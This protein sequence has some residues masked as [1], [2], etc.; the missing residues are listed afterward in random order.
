MKKIN[1]T[2]SPNTLTQYAANNPTAGWNSFRNADAGESHKGLR[3]LI[4][5]DQ[6]GLCAYCETNVSGLPEHRRRIEHYHPKSDDSDATQNWAL[7]WDNVI[8]VCLGGEDNMDKISYPLPQNLSCDSHKEYFVKENKL[9]IAPEGYLINPLHLI[10]TP[11]LFEFVKATGE[12]KV[13]TKAC[14]KLA[15]TDSRHDKIEELVNRTIEILNLNCT[16]LKD[17]RLLVLRK[18]NQEMAKARKSHDQKW[19]AR[20]ASYWFGKKWRRFF[21]TRR[22]LLGRHAEEYLH[23]VSYNG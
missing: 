7:D 19:H 21:S 20:I 22:I 9:P 11:C 13:D 4:L 17:Q 6:G 12:F 3:D 10:G 15:D 2:P 16:R 18:Y 8:G 23:S 14:R 1:K 5:S